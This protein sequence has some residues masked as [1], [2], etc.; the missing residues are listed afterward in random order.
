MSSRPIYHWLLPVL[1]LCLFALGACVGS[2][3]APPP[4]GAASGLP[5]FYYFYTET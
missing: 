5:T 1:G 4:L 3:A 2:P